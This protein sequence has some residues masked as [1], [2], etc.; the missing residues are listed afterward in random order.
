MLESAWTILT[1]CFETSKTPKATKAT[2][3]SSPDHLTNRFERLEIES[4]DEEQLKS[5]A[6]AA[7]VASAKGVAAKHGQ[8]RA[9]DIWELE[10]D[11]M[12]ELSFMV[13]C[14]F[15]DLH[16][17]QDFLQQVWK[18]VAAG[19][20]SF[21]VASLTTNLALQL[22]HSTE[23]EVLSQLA[24]SEERGE[25][26]TLMFHLLPM[27]MEW[28]TGGVSI[29][30]KARDSQ[31]PGFVYSSTFCILT[32]Y[33]HGRQASGGV[34][35]VVPHSTVYDPDNTL[36]DPD[37]AA[38]D[39][40]LNQLLLDLQ[41]KMVLNEGPPR[42][43]S[44]SL[45]STSREF[46]PKCVEDV[47]TTGLLSVIENPG[48][49]VKLH[50]VFGARVLLDINKILGTEVD[51]GYKSLLHQG[52][53]IDKN[54]GITW[55]DRGGWLQTRQ[56]LEK[57]LGS[58]DVVNQALKISCMVQVLIR[59]NH[60]FGGKYSF[61]QS[62]KPV[63]LASSPGLV[64][65]DPDPAFFHKHNPI[66]C[67]LESLKLVLGCEHMGIS[68]GN[69]FRSLA[70][71]AH[72]YNALRQTGRI[73][74]RWDSLDR[75]IEVHMSSIFEGSL[76]TT[77]EQFIKRVMLCMK[78]PSSCFARGRRTEPDWGKIMNSTGSILAV[79]KLSTHLQ[80]Y[81]DDTDGAEKLLYLK[82][83]LKSTKSRGSDQNL[84]QIDLLR[85]FHD[86]FSEA[87][88]AIDIDYVRLTRECTQLLLRIRRESEAKLGIENK[89]EHF[90]VR[91]IGK[92]VNIVGVV[93][94]FSNAFTK[95]KPLKGKKYSIDAFGRDDSQLNLAAEIL[96]AFLPEANSPLKTKPVDLLAGVK[97]TG[98]KHNKP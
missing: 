76:P 56:E 68:F 57:D 82:E 11:D 24:S 15:E 54:T 93:T 6:N 51:N 23:Q 66:Y 21:M 67:G 12:I 44:S 5:M 42:L 72:L 88:P 32:N 53:V 87:M 18:Q 28:L 31:F 83:H 47:L 46:S 52:A 71:V 74:G 2:K 81:L 86:T 4:I 39:R 95:K 96:E 1:P 80:T 16:R 60:M 10:F 48:N 37:L 35:A 9:K 45:N 36:P 59:G 29:A 98:Y 55:N 49:D 75:M 40:L 89:M 19:D 84:N 79:H 73:K 94:M 33:K 91:G 27:L 13:Y 20:V 14:F 69:S 65:P 70:A 85:R 43:G 34:P 41:I 62:V 58:I 97:E 78:I 77:E 50:V 92:N 17:I 90:Q 8:S 7:V 3:S 26:A 30:Q 38:E 22:V 61:L 63:T 64:L 25:Y